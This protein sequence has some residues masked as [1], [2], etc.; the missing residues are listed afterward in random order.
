M[1]KTAEEIKSDVRQL[2]IGSTLAN[3]ISGGIYPEGSR[4]RDSKKEDIVI[5]LTASL[6]GEIQSGV[7]TVHIYVP[8]KDYGRGYLEKHWERVTEVESMART[9]VEGLKAGK[10]CYKF[11]LQQ[12]I[13]SQPNSEI[14]QH[15]V[16][17]CLAYEYYNN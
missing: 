8:D 11:T 10:S 15:Y 4:P 1:M 7:V 17:V 3:Q 2:L 6:Y 5:I 9:W 16:V 13:C 14:S 12:T